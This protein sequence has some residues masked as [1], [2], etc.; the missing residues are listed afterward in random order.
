MPTDSLLITIAVVAVFAFFMVVLGYAS[1][2]E[3]RRQ[4][5]KQRV[6]PV[7]TDSEG[8]SRRNSVKPKA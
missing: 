1:F 2:D 3:S 4:P 8:G 6:V 7:K 5:R